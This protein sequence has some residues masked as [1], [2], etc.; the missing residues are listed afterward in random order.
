M[1]STF[2]KSDPE[3]HVFLVTIMIAKTSS[4]TTH[5]SNADFD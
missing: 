3:R 1:T 4:D 5:R 2:L